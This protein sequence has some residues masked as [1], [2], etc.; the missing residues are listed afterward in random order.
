MSVNCGYYYTNGKI[1][2]ATFA[3]REK[4]SPLWEQENATFFFSCENVSLLLHFGSIK[5]V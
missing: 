1:N 2:A 3:L 4:K 5:D